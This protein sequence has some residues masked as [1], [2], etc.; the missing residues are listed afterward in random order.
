[1]EAKFTIL[2]G[3]VCVNGEVELRRGRQ[4]QRD[5]IVTFGKDNYRCV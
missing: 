3:N 5:D 1:M 2:D 4:L